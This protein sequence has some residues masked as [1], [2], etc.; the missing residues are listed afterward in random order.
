M[1]VEV[2]DSHYYTFFIL[3][4]NKE[5]DFI[6]LQIMVPSF[7]WTVQIMVLLLKCQFKWSKI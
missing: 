5:N 2:V 4:R 3:G 6:L 1:G 7:F